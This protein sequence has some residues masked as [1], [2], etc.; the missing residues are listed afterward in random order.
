MMTKTRK[1]LVT[2]LARIIFDEPDKSLAEINIENTLKGRGQFDMSARKLRNIS[3]TSWLLGFVAANH[4]DN[5]LT[6]LFV[7]G[8]THGWF[9]DDYE[10][11]FFNSVLIQFLTDVVM[12]DHDLYRR[13]S[14]Y[15]LENHPDSTVAKR[16]LFTISYATGLTDLPIDT[17]TKIKNNT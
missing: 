13:I 15:I 1:S 3:N 17:L 8:F 5:E 16:C 9:F 6:D 4:Y 10:N 14:D 2:C 12:S 7:Y 11:E